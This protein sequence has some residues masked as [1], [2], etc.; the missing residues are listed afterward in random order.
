MKSEFIA[1]H[2][3]GKAFSYLHPR[4]Q[5]LLGDTYGVM[6][7][8]E[9]VMRI[10]VELAGYTV[11]EADRFRSEVS[12][13][14]SGPRMQA[15]YTDFVYGRAEQT[16]LLQDLRGRLPVLLAEEGTGDL[17]DVDLDPTLVAVGDFTRL[18]QRV[19]RVRVGRVNAEPALHPAPR[20][21]C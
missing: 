11:A 18:R 19:R 17:G 3:Q 10:A 4:L 9:D 5:D 13:R 12:K 8:Q 15:Q 6:L 7:Y 1:R 14:V 2:V 21:L 16:G 20:V